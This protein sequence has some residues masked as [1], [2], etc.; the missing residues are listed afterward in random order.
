MSSDATQMDWWNPHGWWHA[1]SLSGFAAW[2]YAMLGY[3][4]APLGALGIL[5]GIIYYSMSVYEMDTVQKW[6][7]TRQARKI[8][9]EVMGLEAEQTRIIGRL[10][11]LGVL[12]SAGTTVADGTTTTTT[13][14]THTPPPAL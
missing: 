2:I 10:K 14:A 7:K 11:Q 1:L 4:Q 9:R 6:L 12:E 5:I 3:A 13:V 8:A